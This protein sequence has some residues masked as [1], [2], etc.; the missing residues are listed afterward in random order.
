MK[1]DCDNMIEHIPLDV[2]DANGKVLAG[3]I[4]SFD[5]ETGEVER[6]LIDRENEYPEN[7][8]VTVTYDGEPL[9]YVLKEEGSEFMRTTK[10]HKAPLT[11]RKL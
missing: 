4:I 5:T 10:K 1:C 11:W 9:R 6:Y 3:P 2:L 8:I 7:R